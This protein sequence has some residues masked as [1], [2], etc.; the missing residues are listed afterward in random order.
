[1]IKKSEWMLGLLLIAV[2]LLGIISGKAYFRGMPIPIWVEYIAL[3]GGL[4][5]LF[6][7]WFL[8]RNQKER[9]L[10]TLICPQCETLAECD[11]GEVRQCPQCHVELEPLK[12]FYD[13]HPELKDE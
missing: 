11:E 4:L 7:A 5:F 2:S 6:L 8:R 9:V 10:I 13:R 1:M 3:I 12:G